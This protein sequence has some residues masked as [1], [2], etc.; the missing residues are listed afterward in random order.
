MAGLSD[1]LGAAKDRALS[2]L[3]TLPV[4]GGLLKG[5]AGDPAEAAHTAQLKK[6]AASYEAMRPQMAQA[7]MTGLGNQLSLFGPVQALM[8]KMYGPGMHFDLSKLTQNPLTGPAPGANGAPD[9]SVLQSA[10]AKNAQTRQWAQ[11]NPGA[12]RGS[13]P[14]Q[15]Q[16]T[17]GELNAL[18]YTPGQV[19][20]GYQGS[21]APAPARPQPAPQGA[22]APYRYD[23]SQSYGGGR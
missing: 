13:E 22:S 19:G 10:L 3:E 1:V 2:G 21:A 9:A 23:P 16:L 7:R 18:H 15:W 11:N 6:M 12:A 8:E 17:P 4:V 5:F 14:S 20:P